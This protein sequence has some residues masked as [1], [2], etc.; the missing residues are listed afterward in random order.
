LQEYLAYPLVAL[1]IAVYA[2]FRVGCTHQRVFLFGA[3]AGFLAPSLWYGQSYCTLW[4]SINGFFIPLAVAAAYQ[5]LSGTHFL[6]T[7]YRTWKAWLIT[8]FWAFGLAFF[9]AFALPYPPAV[10][11]TPLFWLCLLPLWSANLRVLHSL[12][13]ALVYLLVMQAGKLPGYSD[14]PLWAAVAGMSLLP[15]ILTWLYPERRHKL[16]SFPVITPTLTLWQKILSVKE[17]LSLAIDF[18]ALTMEKYKWFR[19]I[20]FTGKYLAAAGILL[21]IFFILEGHVP[22]PFFYSFF[23]FMSGLILVLG[24][25]G[26]ETA[27]FAL[28]LYALVSGAGRGIL[29]GGFRPEVITW[30]LVLFFLG[31]LIWFSRPRETKEELEKWKNLNNLSDSYHR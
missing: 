14:W 12:T 26:Y 2:S 19:K 4:Q 23:L 30:D 5:L 6:A 3:L 17:I 11:L 13:F 8:I 27:A 15:E 16:D 10:I 29:A 7:Y 18:Y 24:V 31:G 25:V 9:V 28:I 21:E 1:L 20:T 22:I